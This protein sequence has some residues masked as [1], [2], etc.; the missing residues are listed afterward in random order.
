LPFGNA[1]CRNAQLVWEDNRK[2]F[3]FNLGAA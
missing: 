3:D 1:T 2:I